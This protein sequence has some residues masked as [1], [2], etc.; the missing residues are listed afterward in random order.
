MNIFKN[1]MLQAKHNV[2]ELSRIGVS[3]A[4]T[5]EQTSRDSA[6]T[7]AGSRNDN[8]STTSRVYIEREQ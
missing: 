6:A 1:L 5:F 7:R 4:K 2:K 3:T 8:A